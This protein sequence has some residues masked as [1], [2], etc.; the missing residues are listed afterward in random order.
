MDTTERP[1]SESREH[2]EA[3][4][5]D[6][7]ADRQLSAIG[8]LLANLDETAAAIGTRAAVAHENHL[9][10]VR[11]GI[12]SSL[13]LGLRAKHPPSAAHSL[14][15]ALGCSTW[16]LLTPRLTDEQR[17]EIEVA[18]LLH[19]IGKIGIPDRILLKPGS[20]TEEESTVM[21]RHRAIGVDILTA[22]CASR[23]LLNIVRYTSTWFDGTRGHAGRRGPDLPVG[24]RMIAIVDAF[25]SMMT[26]HIYRRAMSRERAMAELFHC[27]GTQ[28]DP[29]LVQEFS[30]LHATDRNRLHDNVVR[31][32][33][34]E[35]DPELANATWRLGKV[36]RPAAP[37][38]A[39]MLY[40]EKLLENMHDGVVFVDSDL[41]ILLWNRGAERLTGI[42]A[43]SVQHKR[44]VPSLI[45]LRD[46]RGR[47]IANSACPLEHSV[48]S[49][50][51][52][53]RRLEIKGRGDRSVSVNV[54][55][56]PVIGDN[57]VTHGAALLLHDA[58]SMITLEERVQTLHE[59]S[60]RDP[61]TKLANRREFDR[62]LRKFVETHLEQSLPCSLIM[63]DL[64]RFKRV[65]DKHGHQAGD[66][67]IRS[68][69]SLLKRSCRSG[70]LVARYG[71][72][73][74]V[75]LCSDCDNATATLRAEQLCQA[76]S[77]IAQPAV[78]GRYLT[79]SLGVT[80]I[81]PGDTPETFLRRADRALLQAKDGGRN[82]VVQ[83]GSGIGTLDVKRT[84]FRWL[85]WFRRTPP[86]K[87]LERTLI[88]TVPMKIA[89]EKLRGFVADHHAQIVSIDENF[90]VLSI[91]STSMPLLRRRCDRSV[92]FVVEL[93]FSEQ[94]VGTERTS[95]S[96]DNIAKTI[97]KVVIRPKRNRDRRQTDVLARAKELILSLKAYLMAHDFQENYIGARKN[98]ERESVIEKAKDIFAPWLGKR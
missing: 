31:H 90:V 20:L 93:R 71:G 26:D 41:K 30:T 39:E 76:Y 84:R 74:F 98:Q 77:E 64:D 6:P 56:V 40:H 86:E 12:A 53:L 72:E 34:G 2:P 75:M 10:Q 55:A 22:C 83:L 63:C 51:Q 91:D 61:L 57:G 49:G 5:S 94:T 78:G 59:K 8:S 95:R 65:N 54:H 36:A 9:V 81:Q 13:Y 88:T 17:D 45:D 50:V 3:N 27:A 70:D 97:I 42:S 15:V 37:V 82:Q 73:E 43:D 48:Q 92:P 1:N 21:S 68:F 66:Q 60:I 29:Q 38:S 28:F 67:A 85:S 19:D 46:E 44:F 80:E 69:A 62:M 52:Q 14:R 7:K 24:A 35:L 47:A 11:L 58:S 23:E 18:A 33:L 87:L 32:W 16:A 79:V 4:V 89:A 25:D 96:R